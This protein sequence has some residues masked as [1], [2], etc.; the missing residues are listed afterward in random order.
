MARHQTRRSVSIRREL[1][2]ELGAL[3]NDKGIS[4]AQLVDQ[5]CM[6]LLA[7]KIELQQAKSAHALK[8]ETM[9][10]RVK[11]PEP[12][13]YE[14]GVCAICAREGNVT[15]TQLDPGGPTYTVCGGCNGDPGARS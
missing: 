9:Q 10:R 13:A 12:I 8:L 6:A 7:G 5:A 4:S 1:Y 2:D 15:P 14:H 11:A 3:G